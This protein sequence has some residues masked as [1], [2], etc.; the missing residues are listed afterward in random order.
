VR[1]ALAVWT[2]T[3]PLFLIRMPAKMPPATS[4]T[5]RQAMTTFHLFFRRTLPIR[6]D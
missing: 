3:M 2:V 6:I 5:A 1:A 4:N